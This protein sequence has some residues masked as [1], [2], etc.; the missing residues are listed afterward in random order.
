MATRLIW[1]HPSLSHNTAASDLTAVNVMTL[2][3]I[4]L[5]SMIV[6]FT[7]SSSENELLQ[8]N[9]LPSSIIMVLKIYIECCIAKDL[10]GVR[11]THRDRKNHSHPSR[12]FHQTAIALSVF[13]FM[14]SLSLTFSLWPE[15]RVYVWQKTKMRYDSLKLCPFAFDL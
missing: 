10:R 4:L 9:H 6:K 13:L 14:K 5:V 1:P 15:H 7:K 8:Q 11:N 3:I 12:P 2:L